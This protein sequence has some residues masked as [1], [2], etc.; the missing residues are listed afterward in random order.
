[1]DKANDEQNKSA[2][3]IRQIKSNTKPRNSNIIKEKSDVMNNVVI[4][5]KGREI[6]YNGF[7]SGIFPI[8][9]K[10]IV[11]ADSE[12]SSSSEHSISSQKTSLAEESSYYY[13]HVLPEEKISGKG[14]KLLTHKQM[15]QRIPIPLGRVEASN[16]FE[17]LPVEIRQIIYSLY[18]AKQITKNVCN[19]II[20]SAKV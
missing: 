11:S 7:E 5:L 8:Q 13:E 16:T 4:L 2:Q 1:M 14:P 19:K 10:P 3:K 15:L 6:V 20:N 9:N 18:Q 12:N 17:N